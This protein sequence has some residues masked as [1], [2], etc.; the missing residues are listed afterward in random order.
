[1]IKG[2]N[3]RHEYGLKLKELTGQRRCAYC[4]TDLFAIYEVWL[5]LVVDHV[6]PQALC[7]S[8]GICDDW[9]WDYSNMVLACAACNGFCNRYN[10]TIAPPATLVDFYDLRDKIFEEGKGLIMARHEKERR[11]FN[12][13]SK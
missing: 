5:T 8:T 2:A 13:M 3:A 12:G 9:Y 1:M 6:V 10:P 11:F 4:N 7:K